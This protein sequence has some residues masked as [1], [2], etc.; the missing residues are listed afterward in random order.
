[1]ASAWQGNSRVVPQLEEVGPDIGQGA[2]VLSHNVQ[3]LLGQLPHG[4]AAALEQGGVVQVALC[5][6]GGGRGSRLW[7][8][9]SPGCPRPHP[10]SH[11]TRTM[12]RLAPLR[13]HAGG[14]SGRQPYLHS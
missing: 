9:M 2:R 11:R 1:M 6:G 14:R 10:T 3:V 8:L 7:A 12:A 13:Q 4:G 5:G